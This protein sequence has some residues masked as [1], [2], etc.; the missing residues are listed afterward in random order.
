MFGNFTHFRF[1]I[2]SRLMFGSDQ[3][4]NEIYITLSFPILSFL[5]KLDRCLKRQN[6]ICIHENLFRVIYEQLLIVIFNMDNGIRCLVAAFG[7]WNHFSF[8]FKIPIST[9]AG[10]DLR[11][12]TTDAQPWTQIQSF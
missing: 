11:T 3:T 10:A 2:Y 12:T 8:F 4:F 6:H 7:R 9:A 1:R 5:N